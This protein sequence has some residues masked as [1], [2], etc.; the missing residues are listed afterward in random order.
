MSERDFDE[1]TGK[2]IKKKNIVN[3]YV[4]ILNLCNKKKAYKA[5]LK[6]IE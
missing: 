1:S 2:I 3:F 5:Q 6:L 4:Y